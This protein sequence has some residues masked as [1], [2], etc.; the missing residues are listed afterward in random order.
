MPSR[1]PE[2][3]FY[4]DDDNAVLWRDMS[5]LYEDFCGPEPALWMDR[6]KRFQVVLEDIGVRLRESDATMAHDPSG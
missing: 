1:P 5:R 2:T 4:R 6:Q 3:P